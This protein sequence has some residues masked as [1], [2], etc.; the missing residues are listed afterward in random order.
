MN[1]L[2]YLTIDGDIHSSNLYRTIYSTDASVYSEQPLGVIYPK[3]K[4]DIKKIVEFANEKNLNII[5]R[6]AGT[7]LA[8]QVVGNGIVVDVSRY[9]N[10]IIE[11]NT[12]EK[13]AWVEPGVV[14]DELNIEL[15]KHKLF[16]A[17]E[18]S[19]SNRCTI[20]GMV[21]NN[22]CGSHSLIYG[23]TRD[24]LLEVKGFLSD[25]S[26]V[27]LKPISKE[28]F[29][30]KTK[31]KNKEGNIYTQIF[32]IYNNKEN[33]YQIINNYPDNQLRRRNTGYALDSLIENEI[34]GN[35]NRKFNLTPLIAGSE[36]TLMFVTEIKINLIDLPEK[37][38][39]LVCAHF[40]SLEEA[41]KANL[42]ILKHNPD[43][44]E[45][46]D[47]VII[48]CTQHSIEQRKNR[49][50]IQGNPG[51]ILIIEISGDNSDQL[52]KKQD[53]IS[54]SLQKEGL[55]YHFPLITGN[56]VNKVWAL[57]KAALGLLTNIAGDAKP[58]SLVEDTAIPVDKLMNYINEFKQILKKFDLN[59]VFHAHISTGELHTRPV[60]NIK[61]AEGQRIFRE[62]ALET[63]Y[64]VK[65][66]RGSLSGEHGDGRLRGEFIPIIIG[67]ENYE[68][69]K[70]IKN[71]WDPKNIFN[72][73][74]IVGTPPMDTFLRYRIEQSP[75]EIDTY[76]DFSD[77]LGY[78]RHIE[79][80]N[81]SADCRKSALFGGT[82]CPSYMATRDE[83][84][85]T[86][87]R[88]NMLRESALNTT[89]EDFFKSKEIKDILDNCLSCKGC[90]SECPSNVD[91]TKIK[92]EYLQH[93]YNHCGYS[94]RSL[95]IAYMPY[96]YKVISYYPKFYN[97]Y[98]DLNLL[99]KLIGFSTKRQ[100]P[101]IHKPTL[102]DW[103]N[104]NLDK[105][106]PKQGT[107]RENVWLFIDE[108]T[109]FIDVEI[110]IKAII[111]LTKLNYRVNILPFYISG[112]TFLSKGFVRKARR[113]AI[114][115]L[116]IIQQIQI[117]K[118]IIGIEPSAIY[119]FKDEYVDLTKDELKI[120]AKKISKNCHLIEDFIFNE[121]LK[122]DFKNYFTN[123]G[124]FALHVHCYQK[125]LGSSDCIKQLLTL[126]G[127]SE[128]Y[129]I[130]SGCC[131][132]A[133][134]FGYEK[135]HYDLSMKVGELILFPEIRKIDN[136]YHI[137]AN[138]TSCRQQISDGTGKNAQHP[139]EALYYLMNLHM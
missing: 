9:M 48:E 132:M 28:E 137:I 110:G 126:S 87:A 66:Y 85:S 82:M 79:Q 62:V 135:E 116:K 1:I 92:A 120:F 103:A 19:T 11:I 6:G 78:L 3:N 38:K 131:G 10:K 80:C 12:D 88:A 90:K 64:L 30:N 42:I 27:H 4:N 108:F 93:Y 74:K 8:G 128:I 51:A 83:K 75:K 99:K 13:Y 105:L 86:R 40:Y 109:N 122:Y 20:G 37:T 111:V 77:T 58:V 15:K 107:E 60:I 129:E 53:E 127:K 91:M 124:K 61:T 101:K 118:P 106:N 133:G 21:G 76:F 70:K 26:E 65:K 63:A 14:L 136:S 36:G 24:H 33:I 49:F 5:P 2:N 17:P 96:L 39:G 81:G 69:C 43:A 113:I 54:K 47:N 31:L 29:L 102:M 95:L 72:P 50:F 25:G 44:I 125:S 32:E 22:A 16:F 41:L 100:L 7:S 73:G 68:L 130:K 35:T 59:C 123:S 56:D 67:K 94:F 97:K 139:I 89:H 112:R 55:G 134:S 138:G 98:S 104:I 115:N 18:T 23:S 114:N 57:R 46:I 121:H 84:M 52:I 34:F 71:I 119:A 45:L 117:D